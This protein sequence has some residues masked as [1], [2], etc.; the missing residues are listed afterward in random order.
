[1]KDALVRAVTHTVSRGAQFLAETRMAPALRGPILRTLGNRFGVNWAEMPQPVTEFES[2]Q[3]FFTRGLPP[4]ARSIDPS[5]EAL[6]SP[7]DGAV[8]SVVPIERGELFQIKGR[9]Y[10]LPDFLGPWAQRATELEGGTAVTI[11]LR[12]KDY[13]HVH[14][15]VDGAVTEGC[16]IPGTLWPV[17]PWANRSVAQLYNRNERVGMRIVVNQNGVRDVPYYYFMVGALCVGGI[18]TVF[19]HR[20]VQAWHGPLGSAMGK[21]RGEEL[22]QFLFG[23][24]VIMLFPKAAQVQFDVSVGQEVRLGQRIGTVGGSRA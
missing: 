3:A 12:P 10:T 13:H 14:A 18:E 19:C 9:T 16:V 6:T 17:N 24:T 21:K 8:H 5:P 4:G 15:P 22:G 7:C 1:M 2:W 11:Y 23:S 20:P